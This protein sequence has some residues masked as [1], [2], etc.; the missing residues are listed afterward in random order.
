MLLRPLTAALRHWS[1][2]TVSEVIHK[3]LNQSLASVPE[4]YHMAN[5]PV[6]L[7]HSL[8][9]SS[10]SE[11]LKRVPGILL[12][13]CSDQHPVWCWLLGSGTFCYFGKVMFSIQ[14]HSP[15][16]FLQQNSQQI[17]YF[18]SV[19]DQLSHVIC[20]IYVIY[21]SLSVNCSSSSHPCSFLFSVKVWDKFEI[22]L[23]KASKT[24]AG[25]T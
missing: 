23:I 9:L 20:D 4:V 24:L 7:Q 16:E 5:I 22:R 8:P 15:L 10:L 21:L 25:F 13:M 19:N 18:V 2:S 11:K 14:K 6:P 12:F 17:S 1:S 3:H